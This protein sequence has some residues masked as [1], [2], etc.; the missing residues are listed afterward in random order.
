M[1]QT[2]RLQ[3]EGQSRK[4]ETRPNDKREATGSEVLQAEERTCADWTVPRAVWTPRGRY[5]LVVRRR[6]SADARASIPPLQPVERPAKS[7]LEGGGEGHRLE[8]G[9]MPTRADL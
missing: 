9:Q 6:S 3:A 7:A 5:V 1:H 2:L 8:S 4:Q